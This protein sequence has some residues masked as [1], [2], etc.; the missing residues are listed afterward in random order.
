MWKGVCVLG[1]KEDK[2]S[3]FPTICLL[4]SESPWVVAV[5]VAW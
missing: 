5:H 1:L 2:G 4:L 3:S